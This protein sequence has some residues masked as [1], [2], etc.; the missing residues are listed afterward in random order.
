MA[1]AGAGAGTALGAGVATGAGC[2]C[3]VERL[4]RKRE[5]KLV[6]WFLL[7]VVLVVL[8]VLVDLR[9]LLIE[10]NTAAVMQPRASPMRAAKYH[11]SANRSSL[12][13]MN[14]PLTTMTLFW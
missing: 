7:L 10:L 12:I 3:C 11:V 5:K 9:D 13:G 8:V 6:R 1:G 14:L 2:V 4:P